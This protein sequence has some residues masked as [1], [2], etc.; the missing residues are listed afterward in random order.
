[1][2]RVIIVPGMYV[3]HSAEGLKVCIQFNC[4]L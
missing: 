2:L 4:S 3:Y 1:M